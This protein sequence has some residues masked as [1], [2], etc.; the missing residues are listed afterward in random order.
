MK[1]KLTLTALLLAI[2]AAGAQAQQVSGT[3]RDIAGQGIPGAVVM[4]QGSTNG[5]MTDLDG[6]Y[7]LQGIPADGVLCAENLGYKTVTA[8]VAGRSVV[9]FVLEE[10]SMLLDEIVVVGYGQMKKSDLT[11]SVSS[12]KTEQLTSTP[13]NN[14][15]SLLQ[16]R[17]AGVQVTNASQ[18]PGA[19]STIRIRGNSSLNG[20]NA[21]LVVIDGSRTARQAALA[22]STRRT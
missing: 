11:G 7:S 2:M 6:S 14:I 1:L 20:S 10:E 13:A 12:V 16:G 9:D 15:E 4:L 21:P 5:T 8:Q 17:I 18:D 19:T 3:V 22:R